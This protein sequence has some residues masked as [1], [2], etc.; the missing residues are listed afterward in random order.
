MALP[1][2][3]AARV[4]QWHGGAHRMGRTRRRIASH[5]RIP[6]GIVVETRPQAKPEDSHVNGPMQ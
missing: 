6:A 5:L 1:I 3:H 2:G 4:R